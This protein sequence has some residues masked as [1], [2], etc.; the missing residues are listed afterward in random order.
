MVKQLQLQWP[1]GGVNRKL[2]LQDQ[3]P[4]TTP[5][6]LN[7]KSESRPDYREG[8]GSRYGLNAEVRQQIGSG[9]PVRMLADLNVIDGSGRTAWMDDFQTRS[10]GTVWNQGAWLSTPKSPSV[11]DGFAYADYAAADAEVAVYRDDFSPVIESSNDYMIEMFIVPTNGQHDGDY[12]IFFRMDSGVDPTDDGMIAT[13]TQTGTSGTFSGNLKTYVGGVLQ[14]T[15]AFTGGSDGA[16][17]SGWFRVHY[18]SDSNISVYWREST[19]LSSQNVSAD[20]VPA[21]SRLGFGLNPTVSSGKCKIDTFRVQYDQTGENQQA[22]RTL[23]MASSNGL[24]YKEDFMGDLQQ[25]S[26]SLT[27]ASDRRIMA[28]ERLQKLYIADYGDPKVSGTDGVVGTANNKLDASSV[29]D[30]TAHSISTADDVVQIFNSTDDIIDGTY[31]ISSIASGEITLGSSIATG[32]GAGTCSF[33]IWRGPKVYDYATD[34]LSLWL[35]DDGKGQVPSG[36]P[37]IG[38]HRDRIYVAGGADAP[39]LW[40]GSRT[41]APNDFAYSATDVEQPIA[42]NNVFAGTIG[43]PITAMIPHQ[44][45]CLYFGCRNSLWLMSGNPASNGSINQI[46]D[47]I[48]IVDR[49]AWCRTP[50]FAIV[51]LSQDGLYA[52]TE[53]CARMAPQ[54]L[55]RERLPADLLDIDPNLHE[56]SLAYDL[57]DRGIHVYITRKD[58]GAVDHWWFDWENKSFW[59]WRLQSDH[60]PMACL[61]HYSFFNDESAVLLGGRDGYVRRY[62]NRNDRDDGGNAISSY[63]YYGPFLP[64]GSPYMEGI[65]SELVAQTG[66][67]SGDVDYSIFAGNTVDSAYS[68]TTAAYSGSWDLAG[69]NYAENPRVRAAAVFLKLVNGQ[70]LPWTVDDI[71]MQIVPSGK[72]R[73]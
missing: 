5:D 21:G 19:L 7:V 67:S 3:P 18:T 14:N 61:E 24:L 55:S 23:L 11:A 66:A 2:D 12:K 50:E 36:Q 51:F 53:P 25:V 42:G 64:G 57:R 33:R 26:S 22:R 47:H 72:R 70:N 63:V 38:L 6:A 37:I 17:M 52:I 46:S 1:R 45:S 69:L 30:W 13:L 4:F 20:S 32:A 15:Y 71:H 65:V 49:F 28:V 31:E 8:G 35:A 34:T 29:S 60:E 10:L 39:H 56:I 41:S 40:Y 68:A 59:P 54:S 48:G 9:N 73:L 27:I 58:I 16:A 44:D 62:R 43:E